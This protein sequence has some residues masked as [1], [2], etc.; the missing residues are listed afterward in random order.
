M[1]VEYD[2]V[3]RPSGACRLFK[4][5]EKQAEVKHS[6]MHGIAANLIDNCIL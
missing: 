1:V 3:E 2:N 6:H 5:E 4:E